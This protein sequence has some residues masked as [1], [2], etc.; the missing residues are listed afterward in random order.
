MSFLIF[1]KDSDFSRVYTTEITDIY[2][3]LEY[4]GYPMSGGIAYFCVFGNYFYMIDYSGSGVICEFNTE[5]DTVEVLFYDEALEH[6]K[7]FGNRDCEYFRIRNTNDIF[8]LDTKNGE[9]VKQNYDTGDENSFIWSALAYDDELLIMK[10]PT[11]NFRESEM[12]YLVPTNE[13]R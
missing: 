12:W 7:N 11:E 5:H 8:R 4:E 13:N 3:G 6:I 10:R 9:I 2:N 1:S